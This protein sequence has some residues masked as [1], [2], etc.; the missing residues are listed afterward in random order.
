VD[1]DTVLLDGP[2][3]LYYALNPVGTR[4]WTLIAGGATLGEIHDT[5]LAEY[6]VSADVLWA[7]LARLI[8]DLRTSVLVTIEAGT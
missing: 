5:L 4:A 8:E 7:D 1:G 3:G 2:S 6:E